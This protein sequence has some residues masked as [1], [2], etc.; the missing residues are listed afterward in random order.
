MT[1]H[2]G[3][4]GWLRA[5]YAHAMKLGAPDDALSHAL[6]DPAAECAAVVPRAEIAARIESIEPV[7]P[8]C[9]VA[10]VHLQFLARVFS[11]LPE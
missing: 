6:P 8:R 11:L 2:T 5:G 4:D 9:H 1:T 10:R 3:L 7:A